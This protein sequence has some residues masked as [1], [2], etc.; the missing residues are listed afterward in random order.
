M[1]VSVYCRLLP[2]L[3]VLVTGCLLLAQQPYGCRA[4]LR[5][6]HV[7]TVLA[8]DTDTVRFRTVASENGHSIIAMWFGALE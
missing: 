2:A 7:P 4:A 3:L 5:V 6:S 8:I 1:K